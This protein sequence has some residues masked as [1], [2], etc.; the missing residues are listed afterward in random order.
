MSSSRTPLVA[1]VGRPNVGKS[2]LVNRLAGARRAI[3]HEMPGV[4]RD[5]VEVRTEWNNRSF[6]LADTGGFTRRAGGIEAAIV[7]Q[8][9]RALAAAD[10]T[11]LVVD[12]STGITDQDEELGEK[13]RRRAAPVLVVANKVDS[14]AQ[15]PATAEFY[16]LGLGEPVPVS[17]LHGRGSAELLDRIVELIPD[18]GK[19]QVEEEFVFC[20]VGR[21]NVGKSSLFNRLLRDERAVVHEDA[22]TTRDSV[23]SLLTVGDRSVRFVDTAGFRRPLRA[24]GVEYYSLVRSIRAIEASH[25]AVLVADASEGL[26]AEDK[27]ISRRALEAG[28]GLVVVLNKWDLVPSEERAGRFGSLAAEAELVPGTPVL[29]ASALTG[30]GTG[31]V[32]PALFAVHESWT[33]RVATADV[34][35]ALGEAL[36]AHPPPRGAGRIRYG[37]QVSASPPTFVLFGADEPSPPYRRYLENALR[38]AFDFRGVPLR[39][40]FRPG[41]SGARASRGRR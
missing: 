1:V 29:R 5:R 19:G 2:T 35:R 22:G 10:L 38:R 12:A 28:R 18:E 34:N 23:D 11:L 9:E 41:S 16:A 37:T 3:S 20:L 6:A 31:A 33:R 36:S 15:E 39:L 32:L 4:T 17:A 13:L 26:T 7:R 21:P 25:V 24:R 14:E 30:L 8:A 40:R 27:R